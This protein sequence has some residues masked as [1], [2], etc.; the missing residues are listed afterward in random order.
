MET[1]TSEE[2]TVGTTFKTVN[3]ALAADLKA[4]GV[5]VVFGLMS[6]DS[7]TFVIHLE[8]LG[9]RFIGARQ[10]T[11][12][13]VAA[14]G[15]AWATGKL[16]V[17]LIGRG[18]AATNALTGTVNAG[19]S[20]SKVLVILGDDPIV[21]GFVN[22]MG[23]DLKNVGLHGA[24]SIYGIAGLRTFPV[25]TPEAARP[26]LAAA[27]ACAELG[28]TVT[29]HLPTTIQESKIDVSGDPPAVPG[30]VAPP[31]GGSDVAIEAALTLLERS[32]RPLIIAG[33]GA[34]SSGARE[35]LEAL[36]ERTGAVLATSLKAIGMFDG[37]P[38]HV[39]VIGTFSTSA[40]RRLIDQA[41]CVLVFGASLNILTMSFGASLRD[42]PIIQ[43][44]SNRQSIGRWTTVHM[45]I[46]VNAR[47]VAEQLLHAVTPLPDDE[48]P[49]RTE[50]NRRLLS[51]FD[52]RQDFTEATVSRG[53]D[54]RRL[55]LELDRILPQNRTL[56]YDIGNFLGVVPYLAV[57]SPDRIKIT[58][59]FGSIGLGIGTALGV[60]RA[61]PDIPTVLVTGDGGLLMALGELES[62]VRED[63][64]L[65]IVVMNDRAYGAERHFLELRGLP[66]AKSM[67]PEADFAG[68]AA[69]LGFEAATI[70]S[71]D[72]LKPW[73][74][75]LA[76][77]KTPVLLDCLINPTI[78][79]PF[80]V[81]TAELE[82]H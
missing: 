60:A 77:T 57:R 16:G 47:T 23:P 2:V 55:G 18:P 54:P 14:E 79:A 48:K 82:N 39:G 4:M 30:V 59:E 46:I 50:E 6:D 36:A 75:S 52:H 38:Y 32:R 70:A 74:D 78:A 31:Q 80:M 34:Y 43:V 25:Q 66:I 24:P 3:E 11:Q 8:A 72:D 19:K 12:A 67:F 73:A 26:L 21:D 7:V 35:A 33:L 17:A 27:V 69:A 53:I 29:L 9:I 76:T 10:E 40:G 45:S 63:L 51:E 13:V 61:R 1:L 41:D 5:E 65:V 22:T 56:V 68:I 42:V 20:G 37:N 81:E 28:R 71:L 62:V 15:Y 49:L 44:D 64:P 58:H